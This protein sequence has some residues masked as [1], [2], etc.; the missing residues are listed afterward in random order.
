MKNFDDLNRR[1]LEVT[2]L[3]GIIDRAIE[4]LKQDQPLRR[5]DHLKVADKIDFFIV[6]LIKLK[7]VETL[8]FHCFRR[9]LWNFFESKT[10]KPYPYAKQ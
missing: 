6:N 1:V 4:G 5:I 10:Q 8:F 7:L 3:Q 2:T 9:Y